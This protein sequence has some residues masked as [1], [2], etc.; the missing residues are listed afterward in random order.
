MELLSLVT[1]LALLGAYL[2]S[3]GKWIGF[4][5]W[6]FTNTVFAMHNYTIGEWQQGFLFTAYFVLA[7][8]GLRNF[9]RK[10]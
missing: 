5:I 8:N 4:A 6:L 1:V 7:L 2:V 3:S 10:V 9:W